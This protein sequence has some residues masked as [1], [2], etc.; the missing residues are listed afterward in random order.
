MAD[1]I[2][3]TPQQPTAAPTETQDAAA[4]Q[5]STPQAPPPAYDFLDSKTE[6]AKPPAAP[7][8]MP[9]SPAPSPPT[10]HQQ[11]SP[12]S[13]PSSSPGLLR[14]LFRSSN[15]T[16]APSPGGRNR[17][18]ASKRGEAAGADGATVEKINV[19]K[20]MDPK[21][22]VSVCAVLR[23][24]GHPPPL[25]L[26]ARPVRHDAVRWALRLA[27]FSCCACG[28]RLAALATLAHAA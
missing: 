12:P 25:P 14:R 22:T 5:A 9:L 7:P 8:A 17:M 23:T 10:Q 15:T 28:A 6:D 1:R 16:P 20:P 2:E 26:G 4:A 21:H 11:A 3:P 13:P 18:R 27:S 24:S 19:D